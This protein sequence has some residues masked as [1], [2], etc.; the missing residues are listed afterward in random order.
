MG[1]RLMA[2]TQRSPT[3]K[4]QGWG[5]LAGLKSGHYTSEC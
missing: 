2:E 3:L 5:T 4:N 1:P